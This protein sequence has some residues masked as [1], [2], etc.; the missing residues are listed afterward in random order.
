MISGS[1]S[2]LASRFPISGK[3]VGKDYFSAMAQEFLG[4]H[5][6]TSP[7][8][9]ISGYE[10]A[11]FVESFYALAEIAFVP[12]VM[13]L[14]AAHSRANSAAAVTPMS[15]KRLSEV[16]KND[17]ADI[18]FAPHPSLS[19]VKSEHPVVTIWEMHTGQRAFQSIMD[20]RGED[21]LIIRPQR[22]VEVHRLSSG[23][24]RS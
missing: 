17:L 15:I 8:H 13:R 1:T 21:A 11:D 5:S 24:Q 7:P 2:D 19:I 22:M 23:V 16:R 12:D 6:A 9:F 4:K 3:I 10:F 18:V 20:W 14:E